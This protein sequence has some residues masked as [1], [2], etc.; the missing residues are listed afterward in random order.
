M[1]LLQVIVT[2]LLV[3]VVGFSTGMFTGVRGES[4][5]LSSCKLT[6]NVSLGDVHNPNH[7]VTDNYG[8]T[9]VQAGDGFDIT[10]PQD[11][12]ITGGVIYDPSPVNRMIKTFRVSDPNFG[13]TQHFS[14]AEFPMGISGDICVEQQ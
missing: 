12:R 5:I 14:Y 3:G 7:G 11:T 8:F 13:K 6:V 1:R 2:A 10:P 9:W 4:T